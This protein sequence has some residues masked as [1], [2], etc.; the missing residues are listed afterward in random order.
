MFKD[1][2]KSVVKGVAHYM[3]DSY[4]DACKK[5]GTMDEEK[6]NPQVLHDAIEGKFYRNETEEEEW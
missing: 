2:V 3:V 4:T 6:F 5:T 1:S